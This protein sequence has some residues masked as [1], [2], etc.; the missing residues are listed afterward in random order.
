MDKRNLEIEQAWRMSD[1]CNRTSN[2]AFMGTFI[3]VLGSMLSDN[4]K[5][6]II[7]SLISF[8]IGGS[9]IYRSNYWNNKASDV[10]RRIK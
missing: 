5:V 8:V 4:S 9:Y 2:Y 7:F 3:F 1:L 6:L 10:I